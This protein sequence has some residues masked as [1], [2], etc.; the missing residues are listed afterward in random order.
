MTTTIHAGNRDTMRPTLNTEQLCVGT[1]DPSTI[2]HHFPTKHDL[3]F[4]VLDWDA[5]NQAGHVDELLRPGGIVALRNVGGWG[6]VMERDAHIL[7]LHIRLSAEALDPEAR[8]HRYFQNRYQVIRRWLAQAFAQAV[9][10]G[11]LDP[12]IDPEAEAST[13]I[14]LLDGLRLQW[15]FID[16]AESLAQQ[17]QLTVNRF[18]D[19]MSTGH[20]PVPGGP[21]DRDRSG[22]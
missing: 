6:A 10:D 1:A 19:R 5:Q 11:D 8:L 3:L 17:V 21:R 20:R 13:L 12:D 18:V 16:R 15:F 22:H 14:A 2:H 7:G 9:E 4:A